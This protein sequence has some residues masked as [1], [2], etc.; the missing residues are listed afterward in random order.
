M[1]DFSNL[2][3]IS[4]INEI[5]HYI[6]PLENTIILNNNLIKK[7]NLDVLPDN[8]TNVFLD[9]NKVNM[10]S[11]DDR[12]WKTISIKNND[13]DTGE[14][15]GFESD[16]LILDNNDIKEITFANCKINWL[17]IQN[18]NI[19]NINFFDCHI[20]FLDLSA[21][22]ISN[23][24]TLP[25]G[26][27]KLSLCGNKIKEIS[28]S[29]SDNINY[30]DLSDN[31]L[32]KIPNIPKSIKH[33]DLS[34]NMFESIDS[35]LIPTQLEYF[36]ITHNKIKNNTKLFKK[37]SS[38]IVKIYY[39]TDSDDDKSDDN[40]EKIYPELSISSESSESSELSDG[41][42][43]SSIK[44]NYQKQQIS[45]GYKE[46]K[47]D[48]DS[49]LNSVEYL[50]DFDND[51]EIN[52][53]IKEYNE[54]NNNNHN[55]DDNNKNIQSDK[56]QEFSTLDKQNLIN[57]LDETI[58]HRELMLRAAIYRFRN[59][60]EINPNNIKSKKEYL[61]LIPIELKWNINLN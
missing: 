36:D 16:K 9:N 40:N 12:Q 42:D 34:K 13:F 2:N 60:G 26:L 43:L 7:A 24:I 28:I 22:K 58:S 38:D 33:L 18:N 1:G 41:S 4:R 49:D 3:N 25:F 5:L 21:N 30:L 17:S 15:D 8:I 54:S 51:E 45:N 39:D 55:E 47:I 35:T 6:N 56:T 46:I 14:F 53:V 11:W 37:L 50:D 27:E 10:V 19:T 31:R 20:K 29:L 59:N 23:I 52:N 61:P 32:K 57:D 44:L 48:S